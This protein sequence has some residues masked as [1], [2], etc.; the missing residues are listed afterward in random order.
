MAAIA[1][2]RLVKPTAEPIT[3]AELKDELRIVSCGYPEAHPDDAKLTRLIKAAR[4]WLENECG[5]T[6]A[7]S[8]WRLTLD[9]FPNSAGPIELPMGPLAA[10]QSFLYDDVDGVEQ[11]LA[12]YYVADDER[13]ELY[14]V[15]S[16]P[17]TVERKG[18]VRITYS[19]GYLYGS[20][21]VADL[22][23]P[24]RQALVLLVGHWYENTEASAAVALSEIPIGV[25]S[26]VW[27][28]RRRLGFA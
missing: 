5:R 9:A 20:P 19:A 28:Y 14:P 27:P 12:D 4:E 6:L 8:T 2:V 7:L 13:A 21:P 15:T 3:L 16:W 18:A 26:L 17:S 10:V 11:A 23:E 24:L 1:A 25:E 22:P